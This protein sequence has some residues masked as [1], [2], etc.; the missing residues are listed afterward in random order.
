MA[1]RLEDGKDL[2]SLVDLDQPFCDDSA[3]GEFW[4]TR[5]R[6]QLVAVRNAVLADPAT[7]LPRDS[8]LSGLIARR[9]LAWAGHDFEPGLY[10]G[11]DL[12]GLLLQR[13]G[14]DGFA[15]ALADLIA[16]EHPQ[17]VP[18]GAELAATY[19]EMPARDLYLHHPECLQFFCLD[20]AAGAL[21]VDLEL[22]GLQV[23]NQCRYRSQL[24]DDSSP[25]R[26]MVIGWR[27]VTLTPA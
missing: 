23:I 25:G 11:N 19:S 9:A 14:D 15:D 27:E 17:L 6:P 21:A 12:V 4:T 7:V 8:L 1:R 24:C 13:L 20:Q 2:L 16:L 5:L 10:S 22:T 26:P 3:A 18:A